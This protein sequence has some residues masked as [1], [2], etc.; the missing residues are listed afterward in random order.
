[1]SQEN[2]ES[3]RRW[4][5]AVSSEDF[6]AALALVH[7]DIEFVPP[8]DQPAYRG[9]ERIRRWME[10][11]AF[12]EQV[13]E[14]LDFVVA[15]D[16]KILGRQHVKARGAASGIEMEIITWS[17]WTFDEDGLI[18]RVV[19]YLPHEEARAREAAGLSG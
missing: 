13:I 19:V 10:P 15:G 8:G 7:P 12:E 18:T 1:M 9:T 4:L 14:P 5:E 11:D 16:G 2:V 3:A 17:V 6:D